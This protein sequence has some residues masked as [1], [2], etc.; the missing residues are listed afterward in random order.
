MKYGSLNILTRYFQLP[1]I[2]C[3]CGYLKAKYY[4]R[5]GGS[6]CRQ[7]YQYVYAIICITRKP[8]LMAW[9]LR[10]PRFNVLSLDFATLTISL[11]N[12]FYVYL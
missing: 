2:S 10:Y 5:A 4:L 11:L 7:T 12:V 6:R 3:I 8:Q 1:I 9:S